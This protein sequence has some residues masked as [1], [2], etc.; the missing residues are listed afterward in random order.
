[1]NTS[2]KT[3]PEGYVLSGEINLKKNKRLTITLN[4]VA[5]FVGILSFFLLSSFAALVRPDLMNISGSMTAGVWA[6]MLGLVVLLMTIHELI[7]GFFFWVFTRSRPVFAI[8]L[9]YAYAGAPDWYIPTRQ[10]MVV[11]LAPL[12]VIGAVGIALIP[13]APL[14]W[15]MFIIFF[16]AM[17]TGGSAGDLL[18]FTRLVK[19]SPMCLANDT[20]DVFTFY[21]HQPTIDRP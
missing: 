2:T 18:V 17:N 20:G 14:S 8:R 15:V 16:V 10:F 5:L 3:L 21:E 4:I 12:V 11:A 7:H 13:L 1:M 6:V 9:F 19:L